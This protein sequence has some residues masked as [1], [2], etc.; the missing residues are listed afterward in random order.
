MTVLLIRKF[1][2][3][4]IFLLIRY[5]NPIMQQSS[6]STISSKERKYSFSHGNDRVII[7]IITGVCV[8]YSLEY[9]P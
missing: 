5:Q 7:P 2:Y 3:R 6:H 9:L 4:H 8:L 1:D